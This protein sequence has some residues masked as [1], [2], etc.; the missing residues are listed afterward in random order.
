[1][2]IVFF[3]F[4]IR[5]FIKMNRLLFTTLCY[6]INCFFSQLNIYFLV[7]TFDSSKL[8]CSHKSKFFFS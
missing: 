6:V 4:C 5:L 7:S 1:M 2:G 8:S 3:V